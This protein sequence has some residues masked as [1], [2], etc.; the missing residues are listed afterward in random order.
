M[1]KKRYSYQGELVISG[2]KQFFLGRK[3]TFQSSEPSIQEW[4][5]L[6]KVFYADGGF[7]ASQDIFRLFLENY[8]SDKDDL[9]KAANLEL[10]EQTATLNKIQMLDLLRA[11]SRPSIQLDLFE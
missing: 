9:G 1:E 5:S 3:V 8:A 2:K 10:Q 7:F 6:L 4:R 11:P